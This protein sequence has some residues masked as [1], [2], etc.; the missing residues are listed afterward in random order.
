V[1]RDRIDRSVLAGQTPILLNAF[2]LHNGRLRQVLGRQAR[3]TGRH[4]ADLGRPDRTGRTER[5]WVKEIFDL[6]LPDTDDITDLEESARFYIEDE[7]KS[8]CTPTSC[9]TRKTSR[10]TWR[11]PSSCIKQHPVLGARRRAA[12]VPPAAPARAHPAR[13]RE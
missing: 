12:G 9:S 2:E 6:V 1:V 7:A 8:I 4:N 13:L 5:E 10:A 11:W 3:R